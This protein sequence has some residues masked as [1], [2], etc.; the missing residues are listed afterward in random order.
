MR[1]NIKNNTAVPVSIL[2]LVFQLYMMIDNSTS[3][4]IYSHF[5]LYPFCFRSKHPASF[6]PQ[7]KQQGAPRP[8]AALYL[9]F[10]NIYKTYVCC[11]SHKRAVK[12]CRGNA[13]KTIFPTLQPKELWRNCKAVKKM[14][15]FVEDWKT[16]K[17]KQG[18]IRDFNQS[19][20]F[21]SV[22][23]YTATVNY[24]RHIQLHLHF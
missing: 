8:P 11:L 7:R 19:S 4:I 9:S 1:R 2:N 23:I 18:R 24:A 3:W 5:Q 17:L 22:C 14:N 6:A 20:L 12:V 13:G 15:M 10:H 21:W 16:A